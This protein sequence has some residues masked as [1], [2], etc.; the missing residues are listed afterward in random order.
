MGISPFLFNIQIIVFNFMRTI[1]F[2][3]MKKLFFLC[4]ILMSTLS[5]GQ[6]VPKNF[7]VRTINDVDSAITILTK[8][9]KMQLK[10]PI[11]I[12]VTKEYFAQTRQV[13][14]VSGWSWTGRTVEVPVTTYYEYITRISVKKGWIIQIQNSVNDGDQFEI[15]SKEIAEQAFA[16]LLCLIKNS[17][18]K[19][20]DQIMAN[21]L[22]K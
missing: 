5:F 17:G 7:T 4:A 14:K 13:G 3:T 15:K 9:T 1:N 20:Y 12:E 16:A 10:A 6:L 19:Y 22:N 8:A 11:A 18:N 2:H 21:A